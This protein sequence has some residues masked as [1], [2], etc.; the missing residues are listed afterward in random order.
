MIL[1]ALDVA[2]RGGGGGGPRFLFP[3]LFILL[4]LLAAKVIRRRRGGYPGGRPHGS[5]MRLLQERFANGEID[6]AEYEH[7]KAVL[8][9]D[10]VVPAAPARPVAT[11]PQDDVPEP[12]ADSEDE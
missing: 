3:L 7:R 4:L 5:P 10:D 2:A 11:P 12:P 8:N 6:R 1:A 9:G